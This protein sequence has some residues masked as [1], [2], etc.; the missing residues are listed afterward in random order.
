[1]AAPEV[2]WQSEHGRLSCQCEVSD[3]YRCAQRRRLNRIGCEC[4]CHRYI[5]R[6]QERAAGEGT[7]PATPKP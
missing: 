4:E 3:S 5:Q 1:M 7:E 2:T 6:Q